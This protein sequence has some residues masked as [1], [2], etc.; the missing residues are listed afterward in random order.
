MLRVEQGS[1][2]E[3]LMIKELP[4]EK[5]SNGVLDKGSTAMEEM[6]D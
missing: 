6:K 4:Y 1:G 5:N 3:N 2:F